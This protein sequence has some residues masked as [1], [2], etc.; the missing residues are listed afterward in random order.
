MW[1]CPNFPLPYA[2][3][4]QFPVLLM[5]DITDVMQHME[6]SEG[7]ALVSA[8]SWISAD[9]RDDYSDKPTFNRATLRSHN[10]K[11]QLC[12]GLIRSKKQPI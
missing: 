3:L 9:E 4:H 11:S 6:T 5:G 1:K 8:S 12:V 10:M 7:R 2:G